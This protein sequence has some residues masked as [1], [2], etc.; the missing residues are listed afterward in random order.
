MAGRNAELKYLEQMYKQNGNQ[1]LVLYGR[2]ENGGRELVRAFCKDK[3][4]FY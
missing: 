2:K 4:H 3:K 1:L